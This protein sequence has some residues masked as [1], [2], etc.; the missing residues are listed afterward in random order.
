MFSDIL[1]EYL[2]ANRFIDAKESLSGPLEPQHYKR[3]A[4]MATMEPGGTYGV[5][6]SREPYGP[7]TVRGHVVCSAT[8]TCQRCLKPMS[9]NLAGEIVWGL[10][11]SEVEMQ[12]LEKKLDPI[13]IDSGQL[14]LRQAIEDELVLL[15]PIMPMH[16]ECD[17]GW[18]PDSEP[19]DA[20]KNESP[21][22]VL[23]GLKNEKRP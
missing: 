9:I 19:G 10:V 5:A 8:V 21:F 13:L 4:E 1:P 20:L 7:R 16:D 23:A 14:A 2:G 18:I 22:A 15:L 11:F 3:F 17:S 12:N 6:G